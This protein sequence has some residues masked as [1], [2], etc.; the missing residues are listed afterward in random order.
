M[1]LLVLDADAG[2]AEADLAALLAEEPLLPLDLRTQV[3]DPAAAPGFEAPGAPAAPGRRWV[4]FGPAGLV[5]AGPGLPTAQEAAKAFQSTGCR[6]RLAALK[7]FLGAHGEQLDAVVAVL[8]E[9]RREGEARTRRELGN[10]QRLPERAGVQGQAGALVPGGEPE[11]DG[12]SRALLRDEADEAIWAEYQAL[13]A[14]RLPDLLP[15]SDQL[16]RALASLVPSCL[17]ASPRLQACAGQVRPQVEAALAARPANQGLWRLWLA[18][19]TEEDGRSLVE[20]LA[21]LDPGPTQVPWPPPELRGACLRDARSR[22]DW[23]AVL[24]LAEPAWRDLRDAARADRKVQA[25]LTAGAW[26]G[27]CEPLLEALVRQHRFT[28]AS[29]LLEDWLALSSWREAATRAQ[30]IALEC[31]EEPLMKRWSDLLDD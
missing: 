1:A 19:H 15:Y 3:L 12:E 4:L 30:A 8:A 5:A 26:S 29:A 9:L 23:N 6:P 7:E 11:P 18:L 24:D 13:L 21:S 22:A 20:L 10:P 14:E 28:D 16:P 31:G 27:L 17:W 2:A 25:G